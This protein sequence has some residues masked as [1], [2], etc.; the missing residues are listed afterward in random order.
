VTSL[1]AQSLP[2]SGDDA[3][4]AHRR[5]ALTAVTVYLVLLLAVPSTL[6]VAA[7]GSVGRPSLLWGLLCLLWWGWAQLQRVEV[8]T[9]HSVVRRALLVLVLAVLVSYS[10]AQFRGIPGPEQSPADAALLRLAS[11]SGVTL[12]TI[13]AVTSAAD[14]ATLARRWVIAGAAIAA[15]GLA[16]FVTG[17]S[18]LP[19]ID[20]PGFSNDAVAAGIQTRGGLTR[21]AATATHPLEYATVL[22]GTAPLAV[23]LGLGGAWRPVVRWIPA[24]LVVL[25]AVVA[26]SRSAVLGVAAGLA[27]LVPTWPHRVRVA[28]LAATVPLLGSIYV[29]APGVLGTVGS[30]FTGVED[31]PSAASRTNAYGTAAS[32]ARHHL[33]VGRALGTFLPEYQIL[34]NQYLQLLI[35]I[36][37]VGLLAFL[38]LIG[39]A[40]VSAHRSRRGA[41]TW[42]DSQ[43]VIAVSASTVAVALLYAFF[44]ALSFPMAA[45]TLMVF[46]GLCG[47]AARVSATEARHVQRA[48]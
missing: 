24:T 27:L 25:A 29:V 23:A 9:R 28:A 2:V 44:D 21:S 16:Q 45:G 6:T 37:V 46:L 48:P 5:D 35:E 22:A 11:W 33:W 34:D 40:A 26:V 10:L 41:R 18:L 8:D 43:L 3:T 7:L 38:L 4:G 47:G 13:E 1:A 39:W 14:L 17:Q 12:V 20:I 15:L 32:I 42:A 31:D 36:G 19:T 30:L